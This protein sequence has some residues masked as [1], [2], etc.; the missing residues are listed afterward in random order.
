MNETE[1]LMARVEQLEQEFAEFK[2]KIMLQIKA[3]VEF[4]SHTLGGRVF[5]EFPPDLTE[6]LDAVRAEVMAQSQR[7]EESQTENVRIRD[8]LEI[9]KTSGDIIDEE[10]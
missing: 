8:E 1:K 5:W 9:I 7:T 10:V 6:K 4:H 3:M 2:A